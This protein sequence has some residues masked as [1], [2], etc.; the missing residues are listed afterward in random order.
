VIPARGRRSPEAGDDRP[1][2]RCDARGTPTWQEASVSRIEVWTIDDTHVSRMGP[3]PRKW[4]L[5]LALGVGWVLFAILLLSF[6]V[7]T[8]GTLAIFTGVL[9]LAGGLS[10]VVNAWRLDGGQR[11]FLA[12]FGVLATAAGI[13]LLAWPGPTLYVIAVL[14]GWYL[15]ILGTV[16]FAQSL[17]HTSQRYWWV[18][19]VLGLVELAIGAWAASYPGKSLNV[20]AALLGIYALIHGIV[21][22]FAAFAMRGLERDLRVPTG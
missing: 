4:W 15:V 5:F 21:E 3:S 10:A 16:H 1:D 19:M 17:F 7:E 12:T 6:H 14:V 13:V 8:L 20:F 18:S 22:I 11:V 2:G 9:F